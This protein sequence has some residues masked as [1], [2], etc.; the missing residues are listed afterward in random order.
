MRFCGQPRLSKAALEQPQHQWPFVAL[1]PAARRETLAGFFQT[2]HVAQRMPFCH[3]DP[4]LQ[5]RKRGLL[6]DLLAN[7]L[8]H[9]Q[10]VV[11]LPGALFE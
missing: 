5:R 8:Q 1:A 9:R 10:C 11:K 6:L 2:P 3:G 4:A 7:A